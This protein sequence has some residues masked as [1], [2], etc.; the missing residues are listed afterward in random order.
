MSSAQAL[1]PSLS[2]DIPTTGTARYEGYLGIDTGYSNVIGDL[3]VEVDFAADTVS[4]RATDFVSASDIDYGGS[5]DI[6]GGFIDR[7]A[8]TALGDPHVIADVDGTLSSD[9]IMSEVDGQ[10]RTTFYGPGREVL[11]GYVS[12][13]VENQF[14]V[15]ALNSANTFAV[16]DAQ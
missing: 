9:G 6:T 2:T 1:G 8:D 10:L 11:S 4:G 16:G 5:L 3:D 15:H 13:T 14:G 7:S 12:G